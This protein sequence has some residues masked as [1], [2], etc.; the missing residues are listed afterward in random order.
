MKQLDVIY[1]Y[2]GSYDGF[3]CAVYEAIYARQLPIDIVAKNDA[4]PTLYDLKT[5]LT[6]ESKAARVM[7]SIC[8]KI[9]PRASELVETVFL[10]CLSRKEIKILRFLLLGYATG[11]RVC[12]MLGHEDVAAL[13]KAEQHLLGEA[14]LLKGFVRFSDYGGILAATIS[15]KNFVLP[16]IVPHFCERYNTERFMIYDKTHGHALVYEHGKPQIL[17]MDHVAFPNADEKELDYRAL[18]KQFYKTISIEAR[19]NPRCRMTHMP[20]RYW[21]NMTEMQNEYPEVQKSDGGGGNL[22]ISEKALRT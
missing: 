4:Q 14:H 20:K 17:K 19:E 11:A 6:D 12:D 1:L 16:Y 21:G 5:I 9:S 22:I 18:W 15:P 10:S 2:D 8:R 13:I 7:E 3:F